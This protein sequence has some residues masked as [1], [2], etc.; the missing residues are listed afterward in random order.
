MRIE[1]K[2]Q[3]WVA[4]A[5]GSLTL[6]IRG[7]FLSEMLHNCRGHSGH[8]LCP[9]C[10]YCWDASMLR[11][12][13][14]DSKLLRVFCILMWL[15]WSPGGGWREQFKTGFPGR[16]LPSN[17]CGERLGAEAKGLILQV[18]ASLRMGM[19]FLAALWVSPYLLSRTWSLKSKWIKMLVTLMIQFLITM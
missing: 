11:L 13:S 12:S 8:N 16:N 6:I 7:M 1:L 10:A 9:N 17:I 3:L 19:L 4:E 14:G 5:P 2:I 15:K 18:K